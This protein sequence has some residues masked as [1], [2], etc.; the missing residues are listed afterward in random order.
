MKKRFKF[1]IALVSTTLL[2][3]CADEPK[4]SE[5]VDFTEANNTEISAFLATENLQAQKTASGLYYVIDEQG[6]EVTQQQA[7]QYV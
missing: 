4:I 5:P 6:S 1:L 7:Q 2:I 3:S